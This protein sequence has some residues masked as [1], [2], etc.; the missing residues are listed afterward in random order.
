MSLQIEGDSLARP[1]V[2]DETNYAYWKQRMEIYLMAIDER[3]WQCVFIGY[4]PPTRTGKDGAESPKSVRE[5]ANDELDAYR[6]NAK[7]LNAIVNGVDVFQHQLILH[8]RH[9]KLLGMYSK[10]L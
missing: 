1:P 2:L 10:V 4:T 3:V 5:W 7:G 8:A 6:Y 9:L